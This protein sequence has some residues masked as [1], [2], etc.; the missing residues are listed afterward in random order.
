MSLVPCQRNQLVITGAVGCAG[1]FLH[2]EGDVRKEAYR[3]E[4]VRAVPDSK[5]CRLE[6]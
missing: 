1:K 6:Q 5:A 3:K 2:W 4:I